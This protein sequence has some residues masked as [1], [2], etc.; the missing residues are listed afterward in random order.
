[1][2]QITLYYRE[3]SSDKVYQ[4]GIVQRDAG[5]VVQ[6]AYGRRGTTLQTGTKTPVAV[7]LDAARAIY[8]K[9]IREKTSKGYTPGKNG[10]PYQHTDKEQQVTGILPQLLNPIEE[11][12]VQRFIDDSAFVSQEKYD[13]KRI[14]IQKE[15]AAI[16]GINRRGLMCGIP[17]ILVNE[18]KH[19]PGDCVI[20]GESIGEVYWAFDVLMLHGNDVRQ[21]PYK[22]RLFMLAQIVSR[23]CG[24]IKL[25]D[26]A[27]TTAEKV[28]LL[29]RM[30]REQREGVVFKRLDAPYTAG[31]PN[32]GG[33]QFKYKLY[34]TASFIVWKVNKQRSVSLALWGTSKGQPTP[35]PIQVTAGNVTIPANQAVPQVGAVVEVRFLYAFKESGVIYQPVYLGQRSDIDPSECLVA[36]LKYKPT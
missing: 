9:L 30:K 15:G 5:Y 4:A 25:A 32:S 12:E 27:Y 3:G 7:N 28:A 29:E 10:A 1:M 24:F 23:E 35:T 31:R 11:D 14:L 19:I 17:S 33:S 18:V 21:Q 16:N 8:E 34:A 13:G 26:T 6:F 22:D 2:E 36:Q 20:D